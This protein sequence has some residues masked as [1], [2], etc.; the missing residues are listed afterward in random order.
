[1]GGVMPIGCGAILV[2]SV[3]CLPVLAAETPS[4]AALTVTATVGQPPCELRPGDE[5]I[6]LPLAATLQTLQ[7]QGKMAPVPFDLHLEGCSE[8]VSRVHL[9]FSGQGARGQPNWLALD[10]G[11]EASGVGIALTLAGE[12]ISLNEVA[13]PQPLH[14]GENVLHCAARLTRLS[15]AALQ[16]G[17]FSA[18]TT[19]ALDYD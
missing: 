10:Q 16:V 18:T 8:L 3:A 4:T 5:A 17:A 15:E 14:K 11:S 1:M 19:F 2:A 13:P 6:T 9:R 7:T 12:P